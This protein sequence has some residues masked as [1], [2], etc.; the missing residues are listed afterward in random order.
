MKIGFNAP[1]TLIL[2][3]CALAASALNVMSAGETQ[4]H[5]FSV[6]GPLAME[7]PFSLLRLIA[8]PLGHASWAHFT[9]NFSIILLVSPLVEGTYGSV[10][11]AVMILVT[12]LVTGIV[13]AVCFPSALMGASGIAFMMILL[14][15]LANSR[16]GSIPLTFVL[17]CLFYLGNELMAVFRDDN[18]SQLAHLLGACCGS[19]FGFMGQH[20]GRGE[21]HRRGPR[22]SGKIRE[23]DS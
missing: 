11:L 6:Y 8:Y 12:T 16:R 14:G 17:V 2:T 20:H 4:R 1:V 5:F 3:F 22:E 21:S 23:N 19:L 15:S 13:H 7:D 10:R 18:I 9:G